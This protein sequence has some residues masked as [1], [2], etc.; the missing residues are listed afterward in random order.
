MVKHTQTIC[1]QFANE[2][3]ECVDH[4][5]RLALK[6]LIGKQQKHYR[7]LSKRRC[8]Q[9][10]LNLSK[11]SDKDTKTKNYFLKSTQ[12]YQFIGLFKTLSNI[13]NGASLRKYL[14][15]FAIKPHHRSLNG[16]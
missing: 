14:I 6:G 12:L 8:W 10:V 15:I 16:S 13:Y 3:F 9:S 1:R 4:F 2:L 5:V 7:N 11:S